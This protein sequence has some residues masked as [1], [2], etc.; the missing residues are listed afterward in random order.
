MA[1]YIFFLFLFALLF[2]LIHVR[3]KKQVSQ[4]RR[5]FITGAWKKIGRGDEK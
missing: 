5:H 3:D 2:I 1:Y 4:S